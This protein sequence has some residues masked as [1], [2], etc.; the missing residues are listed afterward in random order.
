MAR[1]TIDLAAVGLPSRP[2]AARSPRCRGPATRSG[3]RTGVSS[4]APRLPVS[5]TA[6]VGGLVGVLAA[7][8]PRASASAGQVVRVLDDDGGVPS[9][10]RTPRCTRRAS[11]DGAVRRRPGRGRRDARRSRGQRPWR[12]W[13]GPASAGTPVRSTSTTDVSWVARGHLRHRRS[14]RRGGR[15]GRGLGPAGI[16]GVAACPGGDVRP[17]ARS[18]SSLH[19]LLDL[20]TDPVD[21][22]DHQVLERVGGGQRDVR[23]GDADDRSVEVPEAVVAGDGDQLGAPARASAGSPPR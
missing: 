23:R 16:R 14:R 20:V 13:R 10:S 22:R 6:S 11:H 18:R 17:S 3:P 12:R 2:D 19:R 5:T 1:T 9:S 21:R 8:D 4:R 15:A 7:G